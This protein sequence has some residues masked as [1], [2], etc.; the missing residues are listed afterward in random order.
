MI[1]KRHT[2]RGLKMWPINVQQEQTGPAEG[3]GK[4]QPQ[5]PRTNSE[6]ITSVKEEA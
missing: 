4:V 5:V 6:L 3:G 2:V 1:R